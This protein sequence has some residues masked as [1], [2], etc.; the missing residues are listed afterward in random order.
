[1]HGR[2]GQGRE[3]KGRKE[4]GSRQL[5]IPHRTKKLTDMLRNNGN[6]LESTGV[7][8]EGEKKVYGAVP[9]V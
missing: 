9:I 5:N 3:R 7:S 2:G 6:C 4:R 8:P 1:M